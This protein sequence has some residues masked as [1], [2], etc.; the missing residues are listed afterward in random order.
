MQVWSVGGVGGMEIMR[1]QEWS[2]GGVEGQSAHQVWRY[3][4]QIIRGEARDPF[5]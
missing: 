1:M 3:G 2:V 4:G 5:D